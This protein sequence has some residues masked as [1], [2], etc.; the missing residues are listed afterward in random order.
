MFILILY[1]Y[2]IRYTNNY[3]II[4]LRG[5]FIFVCNTIVILKEFIKGIFDKKI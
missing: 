5:H 3:H 4:R 2:P 1:R